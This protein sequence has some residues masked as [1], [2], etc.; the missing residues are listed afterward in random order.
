MGK[1]IESN[2]KNILI[3]LLVITAV[4]AG[5]LGLIYGL[6]QQ[7]IEETK[8][9]N[10]ETAIQNVLPAFE[11]LEECKVPI[12]SAVE[13]DVFKKAAQAD[14]L[15]IYKAYQGNDMIALA[16]ETFSDN[17]FGGRVKLMVGFKSDGSIIEIAVLDHNETPGLGDKME[18]E[19][20]S[21][22]VQFKDKNP[23]DFQLKVKKDGGDVDA[24]TAATISSRAYCDAV[25]KAYNAI[26]PMIG[27][28]D[29]E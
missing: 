10:K 25:S 22:S 29:N 13:D 3:C 19:K 27:G 20:S 26:K 17:G 15:S 7:P 4:S 12:E 21:F 1:K 18:P 28:Q 11:R 6:T 2:F 9:S 23:K 16:V 5:I 24:I 14:S 8:Q